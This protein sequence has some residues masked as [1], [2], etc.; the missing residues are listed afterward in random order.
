VHA[1][2]RW[3][4][5]I[6]V[7]RATRRL[8][9]ARRRAFFSLDRV[10]DEAALIDATDNPEQRAHVVSTYQ[11]LDRLPVH[12]RVVWILRH[13]EGQTLDAICELCACS[14]STVQRRMRAAENALSDLRRKE[15]AR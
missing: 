2:K 6:T 5:R 10:A 1:A 12:D 14:K 4:A 9:R 8:R 11:W 13:I 15:E 3:L 7:R